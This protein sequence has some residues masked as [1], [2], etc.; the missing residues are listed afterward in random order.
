MAPICLLIATFAALCAPAQQQSIFSKVV[1]K[2]DITNGYEDYLRAADALD[3]KAVSMVANWIPT[4]YKDMLAQK[5]SAPRGGEDAWTQDDE[6][7]LAIAREYDGLDLLTARKKL[8]DKYGQA[9]EFIKVGNSKRVWDPR[10][11]VETTTLF[12]ELTVFRSV[13]QLVAADAYVKFSGGNSSA[14]TTDLLEGLTFASRIGGTILIAELVSTACRGIILASFEDQLGRLSEPD[15]R[16]VIATADAL[17][18]APPAVIET[19]KGERQFMLASIDSMFDQPE[20]GDYDGEDGQLKQIA[21]FSKKLTPADKRQVKTELKRQ[22]GDMYARILKRFQEPESRWV[23]PIDLGLPP[24][25]KQ[26][27][28]IQDFVDM[29][30]HVF[31]PVFDQANL[32]FVR[33]R[34]QIR[35]LGLHARILNFK[36]HHGKLP[37]NLSDAAPQDLVVDP[38]SNEPFVYELRDDGYR[39]YSKGIKQTGPIELKYKRPANLG[40]D[41]DIPPIPN[42]STP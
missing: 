27:Q 25:P 32:A 4:R 12:P 23:E 5:E 7:T 11:K 21:E 35:L 41:Q 26:I 20:E 38:L 30:C 40:Q 14:G 9:I 37:S 34:T 36:W 6:R 19:W 39:L 18:K 1:K 42:A 15:T 28:N 2:P 33:G 10:E 31:T 29:L 13:T 8:T 24:E 16:K 3:P 22:I 17:L